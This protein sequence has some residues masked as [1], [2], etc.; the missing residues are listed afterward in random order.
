MK[1]S[2]S[3]EGE[4]LQAY[5][6]RILPDASPK[7]RGLVA[8]HCLRAMCEMTCMN[9]N[10]NCSKRCSGCRAAWYCV[11]ILFHS[12]MILVNKEGLQSV[13][14]QEKDWRR[15][16]SYCKYRTCAKL[17]PTPRGRAIFTDMDEWVYRCRDTL[18]DTMLRIC[19]DPPT[20]E[21]F[22]EKGLLLHFWYSHEKDSVFDRMDLKSGELLGPNSPVRIQSVVNAD[23][24][25]SIWRSEVCRLRKQM[26]AE[27]WGLGLFVISVVEEVTTSGA[28]PS[29]STDASYFLPFT[30]VLTTSS[31]ASVEVSSDWMER[32]LRDAE[33]LRFNTIFGPKFDFSNTCS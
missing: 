6:V 32:L 5:V 29:S 16:K 14:C 4:S 23:K 26:G 22:L 27:F 10:K 9:C 30:L 31:R 1:G 19:Q 25:Q 2:C 13:E 15:H 21:A 8:L 28:L 3:R 11:R 17:S 7:L 12:S 18:K 20:F 24:L 33:V